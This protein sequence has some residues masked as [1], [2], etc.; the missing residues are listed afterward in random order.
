MAQA[1]NGADTHEQVKHYYGQALRSNRDLR[2]KVCCTAE[3][4]PAH[5]RSI[6]VELEEEITDKFYGCGSP[7]PLELD[8][9]AVLDLG[10]GTGRD[11]YLVSKLVG[12]KGRVI[13]VD[14]TG[15]QLAVARRHVDSQ[16]QR[17][18]FA[19]PN[20]EFHLGCIE[21]LRAVGLG[22]ESV[23]VVISNCVINLSPDKRRVFSEVFRVLKPGGELY[24]SDIF[25]NRRIP[26]SLGSD[27]LLRG[28]C[29][30]GALYVE[31]FRRLLRDLGCLDYRVMIRRR[32][33]L[34]DA[35]IETKVGMISFE[36]ITI[37]A[38]KL[39][40]LEDLCE[41]Y[42]Q[43]AVYRGT[44]PESPHRFV[45]DDHHTFL[46]GRPTPVCSNT[47]AMLEETRYGKHFEILGDR[48]THFGRFDCSARRTTEP[49]APQA[50]ACC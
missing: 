25:S 50:D 31:D 35:E 13:G 9:R 39:A 45:L 12:S 8:G 48:S 38:F 27:P 10:C 23:D 42:G 1:V 5:V 46:T 19:R 32:I 16:T 20:V 30:G 22:D 3:T 43:V 37:R 44:I 33:D 7:I 29:L 14:M 36:S 24:F 34:D 28:E 21:D 17:F 6:L 49:T 41:D 18:G 4:L 11:V 15:S 40:G 47:A 2:T 26:E